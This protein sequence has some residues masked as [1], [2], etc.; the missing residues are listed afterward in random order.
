MVHPAKSIQKPTPG[1]LPDQPHAEFLPH[2]HDSS[3]LLVRFQLPPPGSSPCDS[4]HDPSQ[5]EVET[6]LTLAQPLS[7]F[8]FT[9]TKQ[10][11]PLGGSGGPSP[12][13]MV[14]SLPAP[15]TPASLTFLKHIPYPPASESWGRCSL[16]LECSSPDNPWLPL[17]LLKST[18]QTFQDHHPTQHSL[19]LKS[20]FLPPTSFIVLAGTSH[21]LTNS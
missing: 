15:A 13:R 2:P 6:S 20:H 10:P 5:M 7:S 17:S 16:H 19:S 11:S 14:L 21:D 8:P 18:F 1:C 4:L 9:Q 3:R 12:T